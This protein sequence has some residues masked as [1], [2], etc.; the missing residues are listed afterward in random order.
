MFFLISIIKA[1]ASKIKILYFWFKHPNILLTSDELSQSDFFLGAFEMSV[2]EDSS[3]IV[4]ESLLN[5]DEIATESWRNL[6]IHDGIRDP[7]SLGS[8]I[9]INMNT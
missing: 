6:R 2:G 9:Q 4:M 3:G 8:L 7:V 5:R 1:S